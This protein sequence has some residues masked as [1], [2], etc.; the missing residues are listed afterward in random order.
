MSNPQTPYTKDSEQV[1]LNK[2]FD[3]TFDVLAT[4]SLAYDGESLV[5]MPTPFLT[6]PYDT[7]IVEYTDSS[8]AT[9][10]TVTTKL[11]T[12]TQEVITL[13]PGSTTDTYVRT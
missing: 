10:S 6:K 5:R 11:A 4:E 13:T 12:V 1:V 3:P 8:K 2:S 7:V 9:I